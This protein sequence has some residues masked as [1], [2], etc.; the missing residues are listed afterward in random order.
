MY[1]LITLP[2]LLAQVFL[3]VQ[4]HDKEVCLL[5]ETLVQH[6][7][8]EKQMKLVFLLYHISVDR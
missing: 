4:R 1:I 3:Y 2:Y 6:G 7:S 5:L 8:Q